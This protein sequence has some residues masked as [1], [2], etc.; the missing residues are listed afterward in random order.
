MPGPLA[1]WQDRLVSGLIDWV[2]PI[3]IAVVLSNVVSVIIDLNTSLWFNPTGIVI[4]LLAVAWILYN[5]YLAGET[6]QSYGMKQSGLRLVGEQTGQN[7]GG[8]QGLVRNILFLASA[9]C[10]IFWVV[11]LV[12]ALFPLFDDKKQTLR[13]KIAKSVV[14][15][16][17]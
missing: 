7:I 2:G 8:S 10:C 6:G 13:D 15:K 1:E 12:D 5:G 4:N 14:V 17:G 16:T 9:L 11:V 3:I